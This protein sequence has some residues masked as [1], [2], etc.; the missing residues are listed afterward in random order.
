M[1]SEGTCRAWC[2]WER[3]E[4]ISLSTGYSSVRHPPGGKKIVNPPPAFLPQQAMLTAPAPGVV[5]TS[6]QRPCQARRSESKMTVI[7]TLWGWPGVTWPL[8]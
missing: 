1:W 6:P 7:R 8:R 5:L 3:S 2:V 4:K